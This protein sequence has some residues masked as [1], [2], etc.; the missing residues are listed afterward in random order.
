[1]ISGQDAQPTR[2]ERQRT[3]DAELSTE[4]CDGILRT[5]SRPDLKFRP[6]LRIRLISLEAFG[7]TQYPIGESR[8]GGHLR[9]LQIRRVRQQGPRISLALFP[10]SWIDIPH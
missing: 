3:V 7:Q 6:A 2:I 1:M 4:V 10:V 8:I 9:H 5:D